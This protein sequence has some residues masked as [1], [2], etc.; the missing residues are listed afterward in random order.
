M[1]ACSPSPCCFLGNHRCIQDHQYSRNRFSRFRKVDRCSCQYTLYRVI[2]T[3]ER[4]RQLEQMSHQCRAIS[5]RL[6]WDSSG[7]TLTG[8]LHAVLR[9]TLPSM[10]RLA[11][12][13]CSSTCCVPE[14]ELTCFSSAETAMATKL[15]PLDRAIAK[16][17]LLP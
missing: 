8:D 11:H 9:N 12:S 15:F 7:T 2:G 17:S 1:P 6:F 16:E 3:L 5:P 14:S 13:I 10:K 4:T